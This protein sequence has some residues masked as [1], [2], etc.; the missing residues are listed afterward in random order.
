[1]RNR[2]FLLKPLIKWVSLIFLLALSVPETVFAQT[3]DENAEKLWN[4]RQ[5]EIEQFYQ[6]TSPEQ[7]QYMK[8]ELILNFH[9]EGQTVVFLIPKNKL[10]EHQNQLTNEIQL[11]L[12]RDWQEG[13]WGFYRVTKW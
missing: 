4:L 2:K 10:A 13:K 1:M 9:Q 11:E 12:I 5:S 7:R 6:S 8:R 3:E